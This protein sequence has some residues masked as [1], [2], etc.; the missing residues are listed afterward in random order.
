MLNEFV[1]KMDAWALFGFFAQAA[2]S[3]RFVI[4]WIASERARKSI[5]PVSFWYLSI[6]GSTGLL[7]YAIARTDPVFALGYLFNWIIYLRNL[8][9]IQR[10]KASAE[11]PT[12][13]N[14]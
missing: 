4:Q 2:F 1:A 11:Q 13:S 9:L 6:A 10:E 8:I 12:L 5:I 14:S 7:I 3:A